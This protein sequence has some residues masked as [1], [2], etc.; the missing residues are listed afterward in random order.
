MSNAHRPPREMWGLV[1]L[2]ATSGILHFVRPR[3]FEQIVPRGLPH[4]RTLVLVSGAAELLCAAGLVHPRTRRFA[5]LASA[6]LLGAV[7]PANLQ[8]TADIFRRRS[9]AAKVVAV[10]RLPLQLPMM[11]VAW[12]IW[13]QPGPDR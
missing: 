2:F 5:G 13:K 8:M 9:T 6:G 7:F 3:P 12:R 4:R 10:A 11:W 1:A